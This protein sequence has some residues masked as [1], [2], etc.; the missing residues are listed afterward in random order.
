[1]TKLYRESNVREAADIATINPKT[2]NDRK[3]KDGGK[4]IIETDGGS[5]EVKMRFDASVMPGVIQVAVGPSPAS[6]DHTET[7]SRKSILEICEIESNSTWRTTKAYIN[8]A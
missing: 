1:M 2:G 6:F 3:L 8:P 5:V 4:A 7:L